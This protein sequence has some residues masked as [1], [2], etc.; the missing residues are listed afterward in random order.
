MT[1]NLVKVLVILMVQS[2][3]L[4]FRSIDL[5]RQNGFLTLVNMLQVWKGMREPSVSP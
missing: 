1:N 4:L 3:L 5:F 2:P